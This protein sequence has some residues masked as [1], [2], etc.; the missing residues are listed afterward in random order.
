MID[1]KC[2]NIS[3]CSWSYTLYISAIKVLN[4][5]ISFV[6][7]W[8]SSIIIW[9]SWYN[10]LEP[11]LSRKIRFSPLFKEVLTHQRIIKCQVFFKKLNNG[12]L[13]VQWNMKYLKTIWVLL[14][15][16]FCHAIETYIKWYREIH[17]CNR[18]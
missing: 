11:T 15:K 5:S 9:Q 12:T 16:P 14:C 10:V 13:Q 18:K 6:I 1:H 2:K 7:N 3:V 17:R 4:M 8:G